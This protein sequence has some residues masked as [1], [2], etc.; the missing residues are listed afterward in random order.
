ME[1]KKKQ[2]ENQ[3]ELMKSFKDLSFK[4]LL[5]KVWGFFP[6]LHKEHFRI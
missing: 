5:S 4:N 2:P 1:K 3:G 6:N